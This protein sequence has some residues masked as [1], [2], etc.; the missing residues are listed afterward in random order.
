MFPAARI[1]DPITHDMLVPSGMIGPA[2]PAPCPMCA[3]MPVMIEGLPAAHVMCT[4][5]CSGAITG[6]VAHPPIPGPQPP[7]IKGSLTVM[8]H[9]M[10]AA[11]WA[12]SL[13]VSGCGVFLG[14]PKLAALRTVLIGDVGMGAAGSTD[15]SCMSMAKKS[16]A[17]F[18]RP[19]GDVD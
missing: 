7:I 3:A 5:I 2:A 17:P 15:G 13:D 4:C 6:G 9:G 19:V 11:R 18:I 16:G 8:I 12:P 1:A 14:D 10:P